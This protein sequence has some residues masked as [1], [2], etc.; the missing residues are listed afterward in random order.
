MFFLLDIIDVTVLQR[1]FKCYL[2]LCRAEAIESLPHDAAHVPISLPRKYS[3]I[4]LASETSPVTSQWRWWHTEH[5]SSADLGILGYLSSGYSKVET[6]CTHHI[7][8]IPP[9]GLPA[10]ALQLPA[11]RP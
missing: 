3:L 11:D 1:A 6:L 5:Q 9:T 7:P 4:H 10:V 8:P 2:V